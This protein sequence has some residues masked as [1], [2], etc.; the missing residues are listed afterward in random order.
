MPEA[1]R[2]LVITVLVTAT[3]IAC[4]PDAEP[5]EPGPAAPVAPASPPSGPGFSSDAVKRGVL[6]GE[7]RIRADG[8]GFAAVSR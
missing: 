3:G 5:R 7:Y 4:T 1:R 6:A 8:G 2:V